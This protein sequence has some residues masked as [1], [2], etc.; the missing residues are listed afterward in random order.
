[1]AGARLRSISFEYLNSVASVLFRFPSPLCEIPAL[2]M[3][4]CV[5]RAH[6]SCVA[7]GGFVFVGSPPEF[8]RAAGQFGDDRVTVFCFDWIG[9]DCHLLCCA[10]LR[11]KKCFG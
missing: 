4:Q 9:F 6:R 8:G 3:A 1:V 5:D 2:C 10:R 11:P 7:L